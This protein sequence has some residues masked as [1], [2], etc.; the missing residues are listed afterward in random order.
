[1]ALDEARRGS[2]HLIEAN[3]LLPP[4][5]ARGLPV[6]AGDT[7]QSRV[8]PRFGRVASVLAGK[9][10]E[11]R[12]WSA[13]DWRRLMR[14]ESSYTA[15]K[16]GPETLGFAGIGGA[17]VN[18]APGVCAGLVNLA[19]HGAHP[20]DESGRYMLAAA[21]VTLSHEPQHSKG[22]SS[23]AEAE[24]NALQVAHRAAMRLGASRVYAATL[25]RTYWTHYDEELPSYRSSECRK[26]GA[27]DLGYA[28]SIWP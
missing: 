8:E 17:R 9:D 7:T 1:M 4:G 18:L 5:E 26:G 16:L 12:C 3:N 14:E 2:Q 25:V 20:L 22:I 10:V 27:M 21:V 15:G 19:Y 23:E 6:I 11:A 24:C 13:S 28:D